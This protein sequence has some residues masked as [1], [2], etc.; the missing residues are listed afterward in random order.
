MPKRC[1]LFAQP[2][3]YFYRMSSYI[4]LFPHFL[5]SWLVFFKP[6]LCLGHH[7]DMYDITNFVIAADTLNISKIR[8]YK[9]RNI[10]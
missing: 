5:R 10:L 7:V 6:E 9:S 8:I 3:M 1:Y 4:C 2:L